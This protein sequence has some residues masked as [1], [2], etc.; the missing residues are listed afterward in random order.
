MNI[1]DYIPP[2]KDEGEV[3]AEF[4]EAQLVKLLT[5]K[6]ELRGGSREDRLAAK[7]WVSLFMHD[8]VVKEV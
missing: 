5:G 2:F 6:L 8:A 7:E 4:G 1:R 3:I